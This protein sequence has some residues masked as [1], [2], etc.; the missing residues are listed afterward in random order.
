MCEFKTFAAIKLPVG[1]KRE[2]ELRKTRHRSTATALTRHMR[3]PS[4]M[5]SRRLR[6]RWDCHPA[7]G[8]GCDSHEWNSSIVIAPL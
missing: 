8:S 7:A 5:A 6:G 1:D 4:L 3:S 2:V